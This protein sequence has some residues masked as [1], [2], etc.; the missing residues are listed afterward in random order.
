MNG[1]REIETKDRF[2]STLL[3]L[4]C[5]GGN[6]ELVESLTLIMEHVLKPRIMMVILH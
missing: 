5:S 3:M 2:G 1:G 6:L 4:A